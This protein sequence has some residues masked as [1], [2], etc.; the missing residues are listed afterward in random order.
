MSDTN[1]DTPVLVDADER[2]ITHEDV[3]AAHADAGTDVVVASDAE[4]ASDQDEPY[5]VAVDP[6]V[7]QRTRLLAIKSQATQ[8][9]RQLMMDHLAEAV[10]DMADLLLEAMG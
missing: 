2:P 10:I 5:P 3:Q 1:G 4:P 8:A 7:A 6:R 9:K